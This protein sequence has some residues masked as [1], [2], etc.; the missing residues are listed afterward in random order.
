MVLMQWYMILKTSGFQTCFYSIT[1]LIFDDQGSYL[2]SI[3]MKLSYHVITHRLLLYVIHATSERA[4]ASQWKSI[5]RNHWII[6][7]R[8]SGL[9][10]FG[11]LKFMKKYIVELFKQNYFIK[12]KKGSLRLFSAIFARKGRGVDLKVDAC[13]DFGTPWWLE[14]EKKREKHF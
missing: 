10:L 5:A 9:G 8:I 12:T 2:L 3:S 1:V 11:D 7:K 13:Q 6:L 14:F 4:S